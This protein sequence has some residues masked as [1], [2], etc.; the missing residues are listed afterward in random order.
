[1]HTH[2]FLLHDGNER[3]TNVR[4]ADDVMLLAKSEKELIGMIELLIEAFGKV[5]LELNAAKS[6]ILTNEALAY[7]YVDVGE[8][9]VEII[10]AKSHHKYLGRYL[11]GECALRET[12][13]VNHRIQCAWFKFGQH[14]NILCNRKVSIQLRLKFFDAIVSSTILFGLGA[15]PLSSTSLRKIEVTENKMLRKIAGWIRIKEET[16]EVTMR[17]MKYRVQRA[18]QQHPL[19]PWRRKIAKYLWKLVLRIKTSP[20]ESWINESSEWAPNE[21]DDVSCDYF[22]YRCRGRPCLKWDS[23]VR[24]FC[25]F[26]HNQSW[27]NLSIDVWNNSMDA[28]IR[29]FCN[30]DHD[31]EIS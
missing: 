21:I 29:Y 13:E 16:W 2:G 15:L 4:Y 1:M 27:Q 9:L 11:P 3:L 31:I 26:Q 24:K 7:S 10:E 22:P 25:A 20:S 18:L 14:T 28:F 5:G 17:R 19:T 8:N 6:K 12:T 30:C 23:V